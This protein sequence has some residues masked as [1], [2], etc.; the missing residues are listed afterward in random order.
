VSVAAG[1]SRG[2]LAPYSNRSDSIDVL[3]PGSSIVHFG[4]QAYI[5]AGTSTAAA[6]ASGAITAYLLAHPGA[7]AAQA[8]AALQNLSPLPSPPK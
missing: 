6:Y 5:T 2:G 8:E 3:A 4:D 7:T 1:T